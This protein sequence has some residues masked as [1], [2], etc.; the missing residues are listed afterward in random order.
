M[1]R[2]RKDIDEVERAT[3]APYATRS[4]DGGAREHAEPE[5]GLRSAFQRDRD[6][7]LHSAAFRSLQHKTQVFVV[8]EGD[9]YRT[10]LTHTLEVAQIAR[11][12]ASYLGANADLAE[13]ISLAHDLGHTPF[14]HAGEEELSDAL[15]AIGLARFDHNLQSLRIVTELERRD[16]RFPGLNL[17]FAA[18]EGIARHET[19]YDRPPVVKAYWVSPQPAI[20]AQIANIAD[21]L[22]YTTHD[23]E[24][25]LRIGF[26]DE[27][28]LR[29]LGLP[30]VT[31]AVDEAARSAPGRANA[32][33]RGH[34][35][36]RR[37]IS[38]LIGDVLEATERR[39]AALGPSPDDRAV[40]DAPAAVVEFSDPVKEQTDSLRRFLHKRVYKSPTVLNMCTKGRRILRALFEHFVQK[41]D[42]LPRSVQA[43]WPAGIP[44]TPAARAGVVID[45]V[46]ALTDR[47]AMDC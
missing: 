31:A 46:G 19:A 33:I 12:L 8:H 32:T 45:H 21:P 24:D 14:G 47:G 10:R 43:R 27:E 20:E 23:L 25:A 29:E 28:E 1:I 18:R 30:I 3:L 4:A 44:A 17:S 41:P 2:H 22:A 35:V 16:P 39:L 9:L 37:L 15:E 42:H 11:S 40:R 38:V 13:T 36:H 26:F 5:D 6:R 34:L 7:V